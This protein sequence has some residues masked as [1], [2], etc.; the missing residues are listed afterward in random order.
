VWLWCRRPERIRDAGA[1]MAFL[2]IVGIVWEVFGLVGLAA[3]AVQTE[4]REETAAWFVGLMVAFL[5]LVWIGWATVARRLLAI[6]IGCGVSLAFVCFAVAID[7]QEAFGVELTMG[8]LFS[9]PHV[10]SPIIS[11]LYIFSGLQFL[12]Y[13]VAL[14]AYYSNWNLMHWSRGG[15]SLPP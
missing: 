9:S 10:R 15:R 14:V 6:W 5:P 7:Q 13:L 12:A 8:G 11:I 2:G 4:R 1:Y 3:G